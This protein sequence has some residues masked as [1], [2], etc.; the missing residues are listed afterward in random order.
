M[1]F[2]PNRIA[3]YLTSLAALAGG[4][5]PVVADLDLTSLAAL[6]GGHAAVA[7]LTLV[8]RKWLDGWQKHEARVG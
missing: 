6:A 5:A 2:A 8:V 4:L 3:V 1:S 7:A